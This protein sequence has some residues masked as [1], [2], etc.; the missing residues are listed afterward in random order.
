MFMMCNHVTVSCDRV[1]VV[2]FV[3][4]GNLIFYDFF[5]ISGGS[6]FCF[7]NKSFIFTDFLVIS[8]DLY[9]KGIPLR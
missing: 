7:F 5:F 1:R 3:P 9:G 6:C 8:G 2:P 4:C